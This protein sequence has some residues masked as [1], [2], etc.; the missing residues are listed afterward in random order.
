MESFSL[1]FRFPR[2]HERFFFSLGC[3][4]KMG[5]PQA[6]K[7]ADLRNYRIAEKAPKS[8]YWKQLL[9]FFAGEA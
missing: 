9:P 4:H 2:F 3:L 6:K 5:I 8:G 1:N 7:K